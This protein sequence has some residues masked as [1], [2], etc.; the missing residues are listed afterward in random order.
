MLLN[1]FT[2]IQPIME[3]HISFPF[4]LSKERIHI[5]YTLLFGILTKKKFKV[6]VM[7]KMA[8]KI[9]LNELKHTTSQLLTEIDKN[10]LPVCFL[11]TL[12][13]NVLKDIKN[14]S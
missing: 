2:S 5:S 12:M 4:H 1:I 6:L 13:W 14:S 11:H 9:I 3:M 7:N 10:Y 8:K